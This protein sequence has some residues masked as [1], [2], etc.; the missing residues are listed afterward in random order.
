MLLGKLFA[1]SG[2]A[3]WI[4]VV[5][6]TIT[7]VVLGLGQALRDYNSLALPVLTPQTSNNF[8]VGNIIGQPPQERR[9]HFT[10]QLAN[11]APDGVNKTML[12]VNGS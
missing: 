1:P 7:P 6:L 2:R 11:G 12:V 9:Y 4:T 3:A 8:V 10:V 5:A